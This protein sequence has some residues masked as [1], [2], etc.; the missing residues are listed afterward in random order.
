MGT[1]SAL[2]NVCV[3]AA[4]EEPRRDPKGAELIAGGKM[5]ADGVRFRLHAARLARATAKL[6]AHL[7]A[8]GNTIRDAV[9]SKRSSGSWQAD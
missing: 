3:G 7:A 6:E 9:P 2:K 4:V 1:P 8:F 5:V